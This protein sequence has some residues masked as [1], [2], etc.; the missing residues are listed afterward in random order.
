MWR[1]IHIG[2]TDCIKIKKATINPTNKDDLCFQY[3][4]TI[5]LNFDEV[6]NDTLRM[7]K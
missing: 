2:C 3:L 6:K 5:A 1:I 4:T 7:S